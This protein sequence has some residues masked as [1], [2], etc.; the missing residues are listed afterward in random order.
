MLL[1]PTRQRTWAPTGRKPIIPYRD[2]HDRISALPALTVFPK[3]QQPGLTRPFQPHN[4]RHGQVAELPQTLVRHVGGPIN[5]LCNRGA[6]RRG[7]PLAALQRAYPRL[8][9]EEFPA[10]APDSTPPNSYGMIGNVKRPTACSG[11]LETSA[12]ACTPTPNGRGAPGRSAARVSTS[13]FITPDH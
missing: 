2:T 11:I 6:M 10:Y 7:P 5:L 12:V 3:R 13:G 1:I 9:L 4:F 8:Q